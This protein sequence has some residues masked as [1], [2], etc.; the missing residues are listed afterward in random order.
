MVFKVYKESCFYGPTCP[1]GPPDTH[2]KHQHINTSITNIQT[3]SYYFKENINSITICIHYLTIISSIKT[4][5]YNINVCLY[6][7]T[8]VIHSSYLRVFIK[9]H[10]QNKKK[11][12]FQK[13]QQLTK[14]RSAD[15]S[16]QKSGFLNQL[17]LNRPKK[18]KK[19]NDVKHIS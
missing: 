1:Y 9:C 18:K 12:W 11:N 10:Q 17:T 15:R 19:I 5:K 13:R 7:Y 3:D 6:V 4:K 8:A 14:L 16:Q 2:I